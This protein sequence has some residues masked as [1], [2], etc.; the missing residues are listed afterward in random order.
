MVVGGDDGSSRSGD[1]DGTRHSQSFSIVIASYQS[2]GTIRDALNSVRAQ[3]L[4]P[5][6][7]IVCDDGS[8]DD[9][10]AAI[11]PYLDEILFVRQEH[12]GEAAA[13]NGGVRAASGDFVVFLDAD[14]VF[15][16]RR[17]EALSELAAARPDLELLTTDAYLEVDGQRVRRCYEQGF[18]F[19]VGDQRAA[20][21]DRNFIFGLVAVRRERFL[22]SGGFD[23]SLRYA[24]DWDL[25]CRLIFAGVRV[26][27]VDAPLARY[28]LHGGS[29]SAQRAAFLRGRCAVL[30]KA[31]AR[32]DLTMSEREVVRRALAREREG[33]LLA[34]LREALLGRSPGRRGVALRVARSAGARPGTRLRAL[35]AAALPELA[36]RTLAR[37]ERHEGV[38]GQAGVRFQLNSP[39]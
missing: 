30:E 33:A 4:Q 5:I 34:E 2:A 10:A 18:A 8:T 38:L 20:I 35:V 3:T 19:E 12:A 23:T 1:A 36:R 9:V 37:R 13:K 22:A 17:L 11:A 39:A 31:S 26:G 32:P 25:W 27:L 21:L 6:E 24:T 29:L 16:P 7:T 14:D 15:L 28:R